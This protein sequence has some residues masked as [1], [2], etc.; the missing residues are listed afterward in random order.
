MNVFPR[1]YSVAANKNLTVAEAR[2]WHD[3]SWNWQLFCDVHYSVRKKNV[4]AKLL[5]MLAGISLIRS[6]RDKWVWKYDVFGG[7]N[8]KT[9]YMAL[10]QRKY[11][12][13][14]NEDMGTTVLLGRFG[15][16]LYH[17]TR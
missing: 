8:V 15:A 9:G 17:Q 16:V 12:S 7:Y 1:L 3:E 14:C 11:N 10:Y 13:K 5:N 6:E 4:S 2:S